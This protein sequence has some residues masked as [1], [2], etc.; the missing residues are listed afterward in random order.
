M[1]AGKKVRL[2]AY[3]EEDL[4]NILV[5]INN[6][7]V[8]RYLNEMRPRSLAAMCPIVNN[9][10]SRRH[11]NGRGPET[12]EAGKHANEPEVGAASP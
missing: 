5:W 11:Q 4:K 1:I 9:G 3:R 6:S 8:T 12:Q 2:R 10:C 7:A